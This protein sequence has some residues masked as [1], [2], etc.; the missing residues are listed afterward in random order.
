MVRPPGPRRIRL[1][2]LDEGQGRPARPVRRAPGH[3]HLQHLQRAH[4][5]Q[6]AFP[7]AGRAGEDR[8]LRGRRFPAG[9][10]GDVA[11]RNAAAPDC[12]ALPQPREHGRRG[13]SAA[14]RS[15]GRTALITGSSSGIGHALAIG[16]AGAGA[17]IVL[18]GRDPAKLERAAEKLKADGAAR[19]HGALRRHRWRCRDPGHRARSKPRS[20]PSTSWSTT[21]AC[22]A[23]RR[24]SSSRKRTGTS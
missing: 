23:A 15:T 9:V 20:A 7:H 22:S 6:L 12:H 18:N 2:Q 16:L 5:L 13:A 3:R 10:P 24:S 4:A 8:R 14:T 19:G 1:S 17:R 21:P 11:R